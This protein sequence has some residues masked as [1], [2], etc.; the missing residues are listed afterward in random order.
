MEGVFAIKK[1]ARP[2]DGDACNCASHLRRGLI[3][4]RQQR[5]RTSLDDS[6]TFSLYGKAAAHA[7][8]E[9]LSKMHPPLHILL[10][11]NLISSFPVLTD[12]DAIE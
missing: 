11:L 6:C 9:A 3:F 12:P 10:L 4:I 5:T 8:A 2:L 7:R 1:L